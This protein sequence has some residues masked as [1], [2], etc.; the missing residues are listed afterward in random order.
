MRSALHRS[1]SNFR[2]LRTNLY[3]RHLAHQQN[4]LFSTVSSNMAQQYKLKVDSLDM[5]SMEKRE[6]E[7]EGIEGGKVLLLKVGD[8]V[9]AVSPNC[10]HY[11]APLVKGVVTPDGRLTCAWHGG[12]RAGC[13]E[14]VSV[15]STDLGFSSMLQR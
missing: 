3:H 13:D 5:K 4:Y 1:L 11:G 7:V 9:H 2:L 8:Q 12:N 10:T 14:F 6:V 15:K